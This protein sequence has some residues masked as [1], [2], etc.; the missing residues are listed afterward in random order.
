M[1]TA[2]TFRGDVDDLRSLF[3]GGGPLVVGA[4]HPVDADQEVSQGL[5]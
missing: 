2:S 3:D 5:A 4:V 1:S